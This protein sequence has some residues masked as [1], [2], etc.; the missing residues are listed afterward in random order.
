M[1]L[2]LT[3]C[4]IL[5]WMPSYVFDGEASF[6][7]IYRDM[8]QNDISRQEDT[9]RIE[10]PLLDSTILQQLKINPR[11]LIFYTQQGHFYFQKGQLDS[12]EFFFKIALAISDTNA[13]V[14][15]MLGQIELKR[16]QHK[17]I[18]FERLKSL[19][20]IDHRSKAIRYFKRALELNPD[21]PD[22]RYRL[23]CAYLAKGGTKN[24]K[25]AE[26]EFLRLLYKIPNYKDA[27]YQ[28]GRVYQKTKNFDRA[29]EIYRELAASKRNLAPALIRLSEI[30]LELD[31]PDA[32]CRTYFSGIV[33]LTDK[34][35][36]DNLYSDI[37]LLLTPEEKQEFQSIALAKRGAFF[38]K[39]WKSRDPTPETIV[40]ERFLEH[41]RR[42]KYAK[43]NF[44]Y[45]APPY[46]DDRGKIYIKYGP[47]KERFVSSVGSISVKNNE[48]WS[49]EN[50]H[51]GLVFD[52]VEEGGIFRLVQ[53]LREAAFAGSGYG[54]AL[55]VA[56]MLYAER[57]H[58]SRAYASFSTGV[59][60]SKL[61]SFQTKRMEAIAEIPPE[62]YI[63]DYKSELLPL[64]FNSAQFKG[65]N[66]S[67]E[68][69][70]YFSIPSNLVKYDKTQDGSEWISY[71]EYI[72][73]VS[74]SSYNDVL[75]E[76][77]A[78]R[79][80]MPIAEKGNFGN[81]IL[82]KNL[83]LHPANYHF[84]L[85][86]RN[87]A[88]NRMSLHR[89]ELPVKAFD[90][91]RLCMSDLMLASKIPPVSEDYKE[92]PIR[93][94][95]KMTPYPFKSVMR[96]QPIYLYYEIYNLKFNADGQVN[97]QIEYRVNTIKEKL[98]FWG[99]TLR[100]VTSI[101]GSKRKKSLTLTYESNSD[102]RNIYEY[103]EFDFSNLV[104]GETEM[105]V[106]LRDLN[107]NET[108]KSSFIFSLINE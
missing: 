104:P 24:L 66:D 73:G 79:L 80:V 93:Q 94:G 16:G 40:N 37:E 19:F 34:V 42:V 43:I 76:R 36:L 32:A 39:F 97:Y 57:T 96:K 107:S 59:N 108:A 33:K 102:N 6:D 56:R 1:R 99:K 10:I 62:V 23:A 52:F 58:L 63:Y 89:F 82:Q 29:I 2:L 13:E 60:E 84:Y 103:L 90:D 14:Y 92:S 9:S 53:D 21:Y 77:Q 70:F 87:E 50:I 49:Y 3:I 44:K 35:M 68:I 65:D 45:T 4:L 85:R 83:V 105:E 11:S 28:L 72:L 75:T 69:E 106:L 30:F 67:T 47:P 100:T 18:P 81:F 5:L 78:A 12:S 7:G 22:A 8:I 27:V 98:S 86:V 41:F 46:Y 101:L 26:S 64:V 91:S 48:S 74:D 25:K 38:K 17:I 55:Y 20:K 54:S 88:S 71:L 31:I 51:E 61:S 95:L 15:N